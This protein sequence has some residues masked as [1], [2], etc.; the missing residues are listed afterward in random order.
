MKL[1]DIKIP[2]LSSPL[3]RLIPAIPLVSGKIF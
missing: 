2:A 1:S 3:P